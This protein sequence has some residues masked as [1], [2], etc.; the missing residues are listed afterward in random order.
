MIIFL[1]VLSIILMLLPAVLIYT[2]TT[3]ILIAVFPF[4]VGALLYT[5]T[6]S[7]KRNHSHRN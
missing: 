5:Y 3:S 6:L 2:E 4:I 7:K 1:K